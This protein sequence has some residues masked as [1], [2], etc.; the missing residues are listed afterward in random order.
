MTDVTEGTENLTQEVQPSAN[1]EAVKLQIDVKESIQDQQK[2]GEIR[3]RVVES[4][5]EEEV[6]N[7]A[8]LLAKALAKR[9]VQAK[10]L[11]KIKP[12]NVGLNADGSIA[13]EH[14]SKSKH[15]ERQ[16]VE[17]SLA[18]TDKAIDAAINNADYEGVKNIA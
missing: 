1:P 2:A 4:L 14:Y 6:A 5:V 16:K 17:K 18:K 7:R 12:D 11:D 9:K 15:A 13:H 10:E 3:K 8:E